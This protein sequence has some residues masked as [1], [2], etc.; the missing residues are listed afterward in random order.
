M[1]MAVYRET[2]KTE[3][4]ELVAKV[5]KTRVMV[6]RAVKV[7]NYGRIVQLVPFYKVERLPNAA[8]LA[9]PVPH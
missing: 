9:L 2:Q 6:V 1:V 8:F 5:F 7:H 4:M 3:T